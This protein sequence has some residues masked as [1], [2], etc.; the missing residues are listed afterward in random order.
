MA[1]KIRSALFRSQQFGGP[2]ILPP[3][4]VCEASNG[5]AV[6]IRLPPAAHPRSD[7]ELGRG[8]GGTARGLPDRGESREGGRGR[9]DLEG[10]NC[11]SFRQITVT[12][13]DS[14]P[15]AE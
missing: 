2:S 1:N 14:R 9:E 13:S 15:T 7:Q 4:S 8:R 3:L 12:Y 5:A 6:S 10:R 11:Q